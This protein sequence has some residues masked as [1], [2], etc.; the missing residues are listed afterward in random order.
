MES[1]VVIVIVVSRDI[2]VVASVLLSLSTHSRF[3]YVQ[4]LAKT[5]GSLCASSSGKWAVRVQFHK[6]SKEGKMIV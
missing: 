1:L 4:K 3:S 6:F 2:F 5:G